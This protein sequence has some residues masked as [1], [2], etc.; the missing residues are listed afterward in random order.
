MYHLDAGPLSKDEIREAA[1]LIEQAGGRSW[2]EQEAE[3]QRS[4]AM[5]ALAAAAP[6]SEG[7]QALTSL[8]RM[9]TYRER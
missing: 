6:A 8:A 4:R 7:A 9:V 3:P 2:A 5:P 1:H